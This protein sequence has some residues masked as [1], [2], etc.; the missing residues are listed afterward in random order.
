M[1]IVYNF[2]YNP[3]LKANQKGCDSM[4][5][6]YTGTRTG[7]SGIIQFIVRLLIGA[8]VL[9][10]TAA[11]TPGFSISNIWSLIVAAAVLAALD[12]LAARLLGL[13]ASPFG[14]GI[15]GFL[16]AAATFYLAAAMVTGF[17]VTFWGALIGALVYGIVD[18]IIPGRTS[19]S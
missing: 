6:Q 5:D 3:L 15:T 1:K 10:I 18:A 14:R 12:Y 16:L 2:R 4:A 11:L 8:I 17:R 19:K 9:A 7:T 13:H